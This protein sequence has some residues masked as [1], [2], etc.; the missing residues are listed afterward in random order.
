M[1]LFMENPHD[2]KAL[3]KMQVV[4]ETLPIKRHLTHGIWVF[5]TDKPLSF[6][7]TCRSNELKTTVFKI[8][9]PF[10]IIK[11][12]NTCKAS[13]KYLQLPAY[14]GQN[15]YF[16]RIDLLQALLKLHNLSKFSVGNITKSESFK[17]EKNNIPSH[18]ISLKEVPLQHFLKETR[19]YNVLSLNSGENKINWTP[20]MI[21]SVALIVFV[22]LIIWLIMRKGVCLNQIIGRKLA[23]VHGSEREE[24]KQSPSF[25]DIL[26][27]SQ[28]VVDFCYNTRLCIRNS[29][30]IV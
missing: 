9:P 22:I 29:M 23:N 27:L 14:F 21:I 18:L 24:A 30:N 3:C 25:E 6:T 8:K 20:V 19:H 12:D 4:F 10:G 13:N 2:L 1:A 15:S 11:L 26:G 7:V 5:T 17:S 16:E 28:K